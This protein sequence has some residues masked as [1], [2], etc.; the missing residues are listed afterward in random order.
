MRRGSQLYAAAKP[1][2]QYFDKSAFASEAEYQQALDQSC[3]VYVGSLDASV[4]E[5]QLYALFR[6]CGDIRRI[7]VGITPARGTPGGFAFVEFFDQRAAALATALNGS[8]PALASRRAREKAAH[9]GISVDRDTGFVPGRQYS[10][11]RAIPYQQQQQDGGTLISSNSR[12]GPRGRWLGQK[13]AHG[14]YDSSSALSAP[15]EPRVEPPPQMA[16]VAEESVSSA[17]AAAEQQPEA[18]PTQEQ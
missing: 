7:I 11:H 13:R 1:A 10:R 12:G 17:S 4:T 16:R 15:Q 8:A 5:E 2:P 18:A 6:C 14:E 3:T 9:A